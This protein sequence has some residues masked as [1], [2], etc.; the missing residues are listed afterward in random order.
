M[1]VFRVGAG[2]K[3]GARGGEGGE[4]GS[5]VGDLDLP[6]RGIVEVDLV[7]KE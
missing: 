2:G 4:V 3:E 7:P 1:V 5:E 6:G